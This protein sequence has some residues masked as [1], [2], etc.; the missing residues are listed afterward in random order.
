VANLNLSSLL[1]A[2]ALA[3]GIP[4]CIWRTVPDHTTATA[5]P[6]AGMKKVIPKDRIWT[7]GERQ[8]MPLSGTKSL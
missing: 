1:E 6:E 8:W 7:V 5:Q 4:P 2:F 3:A